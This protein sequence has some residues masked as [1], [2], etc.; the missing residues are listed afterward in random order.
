MNTMNKDKKASVWVTACLF[1]FVGVL[2]AQVQ[3]TST[4]D[5]TNPNS[6]LVGKLTQ[7]LKVTPKQA[8]GGA[9]AIFALAKSR[10]SPADFSKVAGA[11][12]G[13]DGFLKAAPAATSASGLGGSGLGSLASMVPGAAGG[14]VLGEAGGL[15]S[16]AGSFNTLGL[17]PAMISKFAPV[18]K[19]YIGSKGGSSIAGLFGGALK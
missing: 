16:L 10:L 3:P 9:G 17:S 2:G 11:V 13:M 19:N 14:S 18:L 15:A 6:E 4:E 1:I 5:A 8:T 7:E 12:P